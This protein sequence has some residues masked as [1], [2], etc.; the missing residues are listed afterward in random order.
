MLHAFERA[1]GRELP[2]EVVGRRAGDIAASYADPSRAQAELGW[3]A[4]PH[5]RRHVRRHVALAGAEPA[6]L[7]RRLTAGRGGRRHP[8]G[9]PAGAAG[10]SGRGAGPWPCPGMLGAP[11]CGVDGRTTAAA[12]RTAR[13][14]AGRPGRA[15]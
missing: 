12:R 1:V 10:V 2:Y 5:D 8:D 13:S 3:T 6:R 15:W 4:D 7:P 14:A 11:T 9:A